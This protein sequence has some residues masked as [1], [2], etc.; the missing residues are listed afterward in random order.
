VSWY[1]CLARLRASATTICEKKNTYRLRTTESSFQLF[2][3]QTYL[4]VAFLLPRYTL[5]QAQISYRRFSFRSSLSGFLMPLSLKLSPRL[6]VVS[7]YN[8]PKNKYSLSNSHAPLI[9][10]Y[11]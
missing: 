10:S 7:P 6:Y 2:E 9:G 11:D 3:Q 5:K 1:T 8:A 4:G